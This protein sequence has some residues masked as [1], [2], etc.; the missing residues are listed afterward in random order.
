[1]ILKNGVKYDGEWKDDMLHGKGKLTWADGSY[2][3]G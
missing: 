3:D 1:M 2:Y